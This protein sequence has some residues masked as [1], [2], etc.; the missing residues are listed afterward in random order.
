MYSANC[1]EIRCIYPILSI[2]N[3]NLVICTPPF[4]KYA[5]KVKRS[6]GAGFLVRAGTRYPLKMVI[7]NMCKH[8]LYEQNGRS[9]V[10]N[11]DFVWVTLEYGLFFLN[12]YEWCKF[13]FTHWSLD[14]ILSKEPDFN[15]F[16]HYNFILS[17]AKSVNIRDKIKLRFSEVKKK[18]VIFAFIADRFYTRLKMMTIN[19]YKCDF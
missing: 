16:L 1:L 7:E 9:K 2:Y 17:N 4:L 5:T 11:L 18:N 8:S 6:T 13:P 15:F 3:P 12:C 19:K 14:I 10:F